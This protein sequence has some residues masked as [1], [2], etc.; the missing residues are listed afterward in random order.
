MNTLPSIFL[1]SISWNKED[2]IYFPTAEG[3][4]KI[5]SLEFYEEV[6]NVS[7][8]LRSLGIEWNDRFAILSETSPFWLIMDISILS[9][10]AITVPLYTTWTSDCILELLKR[11]KAKGCFF[12]DEN[13][14]AKVYPYI[15]ELKDLKILIT[16]EKV[17]EKF[18]SFEE[19]KEAGKNCKDDFRERILMIKP[20]NIATI[21]FTSG[22]TGIPK[23][24]VLS[25]NNIVSNIEECVKLFDIGPKDLALS[26]LPLSHILER[27]VTY[28][29]LKAG[30]SIAYA[31]SIEK[32]QEDLINV[33]PTIF[34]SVPRFYEKIMEKI[35]AK[36]KGNKIK[37]KIFE[38]AKKVAEKASGFIEKNKNFP[39]GFYLKWKFFDLILYKKI[40]KNISEN[41]RFCIS[42]G[43]PLSREILAFLIGAGIRVY[44]GY[45][46]TETSPVISVNFKN[47]IKIGSVGKPLRNLN[48]KIAE[49]GEI[50]VKGPN[51]FNGYLDDPVSNSESFTI[52]GFFKTGDIGYI[53]EDGF[54]FI[55]DR[56][57]DLIITSGGKNI[58]PQP[59][60]NKFRLY[61]GINY[62]ILVG[63][64][65][66]YL[67][68]LIVPDKE[69][70]KK[71]AEKNNIK[72][73]LEEI[74]KN[75]KT[76]EY[77][78]GILKEVN[79]DLAQYE[80]PKKIGFITSEFTID[81]G[82][83][84]PTLKIRRRLIEEKFIDLIEK[85]YGEEER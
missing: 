35:L 56:K 2:A 60:E 50:L 38:K 30:A 33:K 55:T 82:F 32:L 27:M 73:N 20:E 3:F 10:G 81:K 46:L 1:Q 39:L 84:T 13:L 58:A 62:A 28:S 72:G 23:G 25:H 24:V 12:S 40:K 47:N 66:P 37:E 64:K 77:Y 41:L 68:V 26:F 49:D 15:S 53:D 14:L 29:Y 21:I 36:V 6:K 80:A 19:L 44:E 57:K 51:V 34:T 11:S 75:E 85:L 76:R 79:K 31:H 74:L 63:D 5:S 8:G 78:Y 16:K 59:I 52:D 9:N 42:G 4:K 71:F 22:T 83:L 54:L 69:F 70:L 7:L 17:N 48:L 43:A 61:K 65:R 45:G 67:I 18:L